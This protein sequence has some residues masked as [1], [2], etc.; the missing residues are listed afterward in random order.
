M[1][2]AGAFEKNFRRNSTRAP[3]FRGTRSVADRAARGGALEQFVSEFQ[4][5]RH[6][7]ILKRLE[8]AAKTNAK[9]TKPTAKTITMTLRQEFPVSEFES[10]SAPPC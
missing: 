1:L 8:H 9:I 5:G 3:D 4:G 6:W 10:V 7:L 2:R